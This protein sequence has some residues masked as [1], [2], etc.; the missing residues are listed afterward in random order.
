MIDSIAED[1]MEKRLA[2]GKGIDLLATEAVG[3]LAYCTQVGLRARV[4]DRLGKLR[5]YYVFW[6]NI[7]RLLNQN[8]PV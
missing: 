2:L 8:T 7:Y 4:D 5:N 1:C 3:D 6:A